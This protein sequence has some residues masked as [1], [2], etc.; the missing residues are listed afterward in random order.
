MKKEKTILRSFEE[1][2]DIEISAYLSAM[3]NN[4]KEFVIEWANKIINKRFIE[5]ETIERL[6][7]ES[8]E[9]QN[10][11]D[12]VFAKITIPQEKMVFYF[13][14]NESALFEVDF[15]VANIGTLI[16][17][18]IPGV[19]SLKGIDEITSLYAMLLSIINKENILLGEQEILDDYIVDYDEF[20]R[21]LEKSQI[22]DSD[23]WLFF[24][25]VN[26]YEE[27]K[28]ELKEIVA[29]VLPIYSENSKKIQ[30]IV[31]RNYNEVI[32]FFD[33]KSS[34]EILQRFHIGFEI[35]EIPEMFY[36]LA[37]YNA[38]GLFYNESKCLSMFVGLFFFAVTGKD[39]VEICNE[40]LEKTLK[41]LG[42]ARKYEIVEILCENPCNGKELAQKLGITQ[43]TISHH[44]SQL[45]ENSIVMVQ[46]NKENVSNYYVDKE[47][48][49]KHFESLSKKFKN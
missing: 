21:R 33:E 11:F 48:L 47:R 24:Q 30:D 3:A 4:E 18:G 16:L 28:K 14:N 8:S 40:E 2:G 9:L 44:M 15:G 37:M 34:E 12:E 25:I 10:F 41:C 39:E 27:Y 36:S 38:A 23:K 31:E 19:V 32:S 5:K 46:I 6:Q 1:F 7:K 45:I 42:E 17:A 49:S 26:H 13:K 20:M 29:S 43:A 22:N 35:E